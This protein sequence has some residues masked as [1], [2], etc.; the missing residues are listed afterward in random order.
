[1]KRR[2][3]TG[4]VVIAVLAARWP[5]ASDAA[6]D[7]PVTTITHDRPHVHVSGG[8]GACPV[9]SVHSE[10]TLR[11]TVYS[12]GKDVTHAVDFHITYTNP[13][14]GKTLT[15]VLAGPFIVEPN[16]DGTVTVTI[17]GNDGHLTA[18]GQ[19][20]IFADRRQARLHRRS[21]RRLHA[22]R[23][24]EVDRTARIRA[25]SRRP[26]RDSPSSPAPASR[27]L[28]SGAGR[29]PLRA[30]YCAWATRSAQ[31]VQQ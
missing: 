27:L 12:N 5:L 14:N 2:S 19:G 23:D 20:T 26:A 30:R 21:A 22:A 8:R 7:Q 4:V 25:S 29:V 1:M 24:R 16:A 13:A 10:G 9:P 11:D 15:T 17:N 3:F 18:P 31:R 28:P 6:A